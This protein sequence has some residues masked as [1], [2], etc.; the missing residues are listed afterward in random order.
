[1]S[2]HYQLSGW[3]GAGNNENKQ[4]TAVGGLRRLRLGEYECCDYLCFG[5]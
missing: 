2:E 5:V 1:M 3:Q 4:S